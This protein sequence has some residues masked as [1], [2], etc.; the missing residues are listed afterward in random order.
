MH[1]GRKYSRPFEILLILEELALQFGSIYDHEHCGLLSPLSSPGLTQQQGGDGD[2]GKCLS[3]SLG[4][5]DEAPA[6]FWVTDALHDLLHGA[7][8]VLTENLKTFFLLV[9]Q[10]AP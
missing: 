10:V 9:D 4:V 3:A 2:H 5:P 7:G 6:L 8:L 1:A